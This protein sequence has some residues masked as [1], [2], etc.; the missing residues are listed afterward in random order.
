M[1]AGESTS[2]SPARRRSFGLAPCRHLV[3]ARLD[4]RPRPDRREVLEAR[5]FLLEEL[6]GDI[7][8]MALRRIT[9]WLEQQPR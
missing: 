1:R 8:E 7:G 5:F 9:I 3:A 2:R 6:P 4:G